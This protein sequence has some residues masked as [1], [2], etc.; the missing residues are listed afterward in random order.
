[1][2]SAFSNITYRNTINEAIK[3]STEKTNIKKR[4]IYLT[5]NYDVNNVFLQNIGKIVNELSNGFFISNDKK[6]GSIDALM[7][8]FKTGMVIRIISND[9]FELGYV[10]PNIDNTP[11]DNIEK[12]FN[13]AANE[14][15]I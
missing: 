10:Y 8:D 7:S 9:V 13:I 6:Y 15:C 1:M 11:V 2:I 14:Y 12:I 4:I 3:L 5:H